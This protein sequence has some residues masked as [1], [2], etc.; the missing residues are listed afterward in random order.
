[1]DVD[2][3]RVVNGLGRACFDRVKEFNSQ[4]PPIAYGLLHLLGVSDAHVI[5][6]I[7]QACVGRVRDFNPQTAANSIWAIAT[8]GVSDAQIFT[9]LS[10]ERGVCENG[11][12][13]F[14]S[15]MRSL[16]LIHFLLLA[17]N[18]RDQLHFL[19]SSYLPISLASLHLE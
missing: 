6:A 2:D 17:A 16:T 5:A 7:A 1:M 13:I 3:P 9:T 14:F 15:S 10:Q 19:D 18:T 11:V 8:L 4:T 12:E